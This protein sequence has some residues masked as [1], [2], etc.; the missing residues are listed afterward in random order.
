MRKNLFVYYCAKHYVI[1]AVQQ[2]CLAAQPAIRLEIIVQIQKSFANLQ[3]HL[4]LVPIVEDPLGTGYLLKTTIFL[5]REQSQCPVIRRLLH[6]VVSI[7]WLHIRVGSELQSIGVVQF[8]QE[9]GVAPLVSLEFYQASLIKAFLPNCLELP[10][11]QIGNNRLAHL[12]E[13]FFH[14]ILMNR[15]PILFFIL[16]G[17]GS[18][19]R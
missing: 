11:L 8:F 10:L 19:Q 3:Q 9:R 6:H 2:H 18:S 4:D 7:N 1:G 13:L 15:D 16:I 12:K 17:K 5:I 14:W